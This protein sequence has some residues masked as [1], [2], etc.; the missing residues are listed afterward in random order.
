MSVAVP[1]YKNACIAPER[2]GA[3]VWLIG[4]SPVSEGRLEAYT[5]SLSNINAPTATLVASQLD[6]LA[7][8]SQAEKACFNFP[9]LGPSMSS[10]ILLQQFGPKSYFTN[11]FPNG[12]FESAANFQS[13]GFVSP[14]LASLSGAVGDL[15]WLTAVANVSSVR[16]NSPWTGVRLNGTD[17]YNSVQDYI[18]TQYPT[19]NPLLSVGAYVPSSNTPAQGYHIVFDNIGGGVAYTTLASAGSIVSNLDRILSLSNPQS[20]DMN[21]IKLTKDAIPITMASVAYILDRALDGSCVLYTLNPSQSMQLQRVP[22]KGDVPPFSA[23]IAATILNSRIVIYGA[24]SGT[25]ATSRFNAFDTVDGTW[26]GPG[27]VKVNVT[28]SN[29]STPSGGQPAPTSISPSGDPDKGAPL[30]A[31]IGGVVGG[32]VLIALVAFLAIRHRRKPKPAST[33]I[34]VATTGDAGPVMAAAAAGAGA[35]FSVPGKNDGFLT[36]QPPMQQSYS[37]LQQNQQQSI[38]QAQFSQQQQQQQYNPHHSYIPPA[39]VEPAKD[40]SASSQQQQSPVLFQNQQHHS[41]VPPTI[42]A[43]AQQPAQPNIFQPQS[44]ASSNPRYSHATYTPSVSTPQASYT[45]AS[46]VHTSPT[47]ATSGPQHF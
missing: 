13:M 33:A 45:L 22:I 26:S 14:R 36:N 38:Q 20:V 35:A 7:W 21:G 24:S 43:N 46:Q 9:G 37:P 1:A 17:L 29:G 5:V 40:G 32:L 44:E 16:T 42:N 28:P 47:G 12:T 2:S 4:V 19:S 11:I 34:T 27:L 15:N 25:T 23:S 6:V 10:P 8:S 41:Y 3:A 39:Y 31:I 30:G 18:L